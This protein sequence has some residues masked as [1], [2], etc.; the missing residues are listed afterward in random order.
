MH[1]VE[2]FETDGATLV[3]IAKD[4][5]EYVPLP[6][7][8]FEDGK[9]LT[10]WGLTEAERLAIAHGENLRLWV[11]VFPHRCAHCGHVEAGKL[12]PVALDVTDER[13]G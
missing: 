2:Q 9:V 4:Q 7:L 11:W 12:Q 3:V 13:K 8:V 5:P 10:E 6:A 1:P